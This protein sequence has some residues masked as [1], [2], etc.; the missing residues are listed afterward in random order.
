MIS[1]F[2]TFTLCLLWIQVRQQQLAENI[3]YMFVRYIK[4]RCCRQRARKS[5]SPCRRSRT[6]EIGEK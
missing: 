2:R 4:Y 1:V 6:Q 5:E 3:V